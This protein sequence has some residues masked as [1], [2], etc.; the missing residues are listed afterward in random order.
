MNKNLFLTA[1]LTL[2]VGCS[3]NKGE[4]S[5]PI[6]FDDPAFKNYCL[7]KFDSDGD[8]TVTDKEIKQVT[9]LTLDANKNMSLVGVKSLAGIEYFTE[10]KE[11]S[12]IKCEFTSV[13]LSHNKKL[14]S[15]AMMYGKLSSLDVS[16]LPELETLNCNSNSLTTLDLTKNPKLKYLY[17]QGNKLT[18][19]DVSNTPLLEQLYV[20]ITNTMSNSIEKLDVTKCP[21][22]KQLYAIG[23]TS[24]KEL[25]M[26]QTHD[27]ANIL[28]D[29]PNTTKII[30]E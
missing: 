19:L 2:L 3:D 8:G 16:I 4:D 15:L 24:L 6:T 29:V 21:N 22:L 28:M 18:K 14:N 1:C 9:K 11:F 25:R 10:L 23:M 17:V 20:S 12:C 27:D 26:L 13:N 30:Y 7:E 5:K